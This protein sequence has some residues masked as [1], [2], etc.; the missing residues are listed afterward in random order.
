MSRKLFT[1]GC[2]VLIVLGL[3]HLLGHYSLTTSPGATEGDRQLVAMMRANPQDMGL[4]FE[5][6]MFDLVTGFSLTFS[7]LPLAMGLVGFV[8]RRHATTAPGLLRQTAI[9]Y[10]GT[11]GI[12]TGVALRYWFPAPL[13]FLALAFVCFTAAVATAPRA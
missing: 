10:A 11:Y 6:S 1:A 3:G 9:A 13:F 7:V 8:V 12:M 2:V 4:G 5:R